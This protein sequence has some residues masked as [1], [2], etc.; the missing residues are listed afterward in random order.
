MK[1]R[2]TDVAGPL[3]RRR[4]FTVVVGVYILLTLILSAFLTA[5]YLPLLFGALILAFAPLLP[6]KSESRPVD[7]TVRAGYIDIENAGLLSH[8]LRATE[9]AAAS[10][11][12]TEGGLALALARR[13]RELE[14]PLILEVKTEREVTA[15]REALGLGYHGH[16]G[17]VWPV[18]VPPMQ[19]FFSTLRALCLAAFVTLAG[20]RP[21]WD[22]WTGLLYPMVILAIL[23]FVKPG[24]VPS[25]WLRQDGVHYFDGK[26]WRFIA[27]PALASAHVGEHQLTVVGTDAQCPR[28]VVPLRE[29]SFG[30][31][32]ITRLTAEH[33]AAQLDG[34]A[35]R[36]RGE[37]TLGPQV[38]ASVELFARAEGEPLHD[39]LARLDATASALAAGSG[40]RSGA[41][42]EEDLWDALAN[43]DADPGIRMAAARILSRASRDASDR[44][45]TIVATVR[46]EKAQKR[47]RVALDYDIE[48]ASRELDELETTELLESVGLPA[49]AGGEED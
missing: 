4:V 35:R 31:F 36:A 5:L 1:A 33:I 48:D 23:A 7:L 14:P 2:L 12:R 44:I 24:P 11:T 19:G 49:R 9:I 18:S 43:P 42:A 13:T 39:W 16:G 21:G 15:I 10:T 45:D 25:L 41:P 34:C 20:H 40:Y 17:L 30:P 29:W 8:R 38:S 27:Y 46:E 37:G 6:R 32:G 28:L 3:K 47:I 26:S 22:V